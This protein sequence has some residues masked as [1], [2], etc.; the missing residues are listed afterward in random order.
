MT[1]DGKGSAQVTGDGKGSAQVSQAE[2]STLFDVSRERGDE[3][4]D[5]GSGARFEVVPLRGAGEAVQAGGRHS[6]TPTRDIFLHMDTVDHRTRILDQF[7]KQAVPFAEVP[8]HADLD[9]MALLV[10]L[11][12]ANVDDEVLD[13]GCGPG[14]VACA[15]APLVRSV[16]GTD[17]TPAM[18][19]RAAD[20]ARGRGIANVTFLPGD[21]ERLPFEA[22]RF[23]LVVTR[24]TFHHL[25]SPRKALAE[26]VRVCRHG[27]RVA[28]VDAALPSAKAG[29]YDAL[30]LVRDPSHVHALSPEELLGLAQEAG[31]RDVQTAL[32]RLS[33]GLEHTLAASFPDPGGAERVRTVVES[34]IGVDALGIQAWR[35]ASGAVWYRVPCAVVVGRKE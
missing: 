22:A 33:I 32:Y 25:L 20:L 24:Y 14:L 7:S 30:E 12:G 5:A 29:A 13:A 2:R 3:L 28:I 1:G 21:M 27:G 23:S 18:L 15:L 26:M 11:S 10:R 31:L 16:T 35:D 4:V 19:T 9:A 8:A 34:D 17:V 6:G